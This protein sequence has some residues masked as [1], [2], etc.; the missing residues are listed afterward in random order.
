MDKVGQ[1]IVTGG[2]GAF[3]VNADSS[4]SNKTPSP[5]PTDAKGTGDKTQ[6][7]TQTPE[8][9]LA[10]P[11][12]PK[13]KTDLVLLTEEECRSIIGFGKHMPV[14][15]STADSGSSG[16]KPEPP[17]ATSASTVAAGPNE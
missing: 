4:A 7:T 12:L 8:P 6:Q 3:S 14:F 11:L 9:T 13:A 2:F 17:E 15:D 10:A 1:P 5:A 16:S